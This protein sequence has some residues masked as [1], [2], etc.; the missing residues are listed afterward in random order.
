MSEKEQQIS[1]QNDPNAEL[2]EPLASHSN[3]LKLPDGFPIPEKLEIDAVQF[4][5]WKRALDDISV[6]HPVWRQ[7][8]TNLAEAIQVIHFDEFLSQFAKQ[9]EYL[10]EYVVD[11][12]FSRV[13]LIVPE[14]STSNGE[15]RTK[16]DHWVAALLRENASFNLSVEFAEV[17]RRSVVKHTGIGEKDLLL[18]ADNCVYTGNQLGQRIGKSLPSGFRPPLKVM[19]P[20]MSLGGVDALLRYSEIHQDQIVP[21]KRILQIK[22]IAY[23]DI[24]SSDMLL[25]RKMLEDVFYNG[26]VPVESQTLTVFDFHSPP[27][28]VSFPE[29]IA[30]GNVA[31][32][33]GTGDYHNGRNEASYPFLPKVKPPYRSW[34]FAT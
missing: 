9:L 7:I 30:K 25:A 23:R 28:Y 31:W 32:S 34:H 10:T 4:E 22:D 29:Q 20:C 11:H 13:R 27:D 18:F 16:S 2:Q 19:V 24:S 15:P 6:V 8:W 21:F 33:S 1:R 5:K 26:E 12:N 17:F 3:E 14:I